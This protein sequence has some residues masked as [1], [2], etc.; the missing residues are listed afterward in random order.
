LTTRTVGDD[1]AR[2]ASFVGN[3]TG[4]VVYPPFVGL[5]LE[6]N[7]ELVAGVVLNC[8]TGHDIN[9]CL[10]SDRGAITRRFMREV[11]DYV[12]RQA[13]C[14]RVTIETASS[15]VAELAL[16]VGGLVEGVKRDA[17]GPGR[18][19]FVLGILKADW[20]L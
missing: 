16:R 2:V 15:E 20:P 5:G 8:Y 14:D 3:R 18:N 10:A 9:L 4:V 13:Q 19:A 6:R 11:A 12:W 17:Y 7:G 1:P